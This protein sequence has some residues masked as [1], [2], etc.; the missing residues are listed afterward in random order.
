MLNEPKILED[1]L[2]HVTRGETLR[3]KCTIDV[4]ADTHYVLS[5]KT[6]QNVLTLFLFDHNINCNVQKFRRCR[7]FSSLV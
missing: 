1:T 6:P 4:E 2:S 3:V 5:W 7:I